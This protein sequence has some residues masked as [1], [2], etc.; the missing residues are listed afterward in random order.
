MKSDTLQPKCQF[1]IDPGGSLRELRI[2]YSPCPNDTYIFHDLVHRNVNV[3]GYR[4]VEELHDVETLN[5]MA[6]DGILELTKLSFHAFL[7]LGDRYR[8]LRAGAAMGHGCG[9]LVVARRRLSRRELRT[10]RVVLPGEWTSAHLLFRL[11][12]PEVE[13]RFF[14]RYDRI[15]ETVRAGNADCGVIIHE[16][17][18]TYQRAGFQALVDLG[19]WWERETGLPIPLG[20]I[21]A[22]ADVPDDVKTAVECAIRKSIRNA[23]AAPER[24][25]PY[26]RRHASEMDAEVLD[27]HIRTFVNDYSLDLGSRGLEAVSVLR[28]RSREAGV[29]P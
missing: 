7:R 4:I 11:W 29:T 5:R 6:S 26:V 17:R 3:P 19:E 9:P 12:A 18:F 8:L 16:N 25:L 2:G 22:R 28:Q 13:N 27:R 10:C 20:C 23:M 1:P 14:T 21:A 15:L 24:C